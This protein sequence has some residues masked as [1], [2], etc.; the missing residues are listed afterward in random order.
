[1]KND[2]SPEI[3]HHG[4]HHQV[5][6]SC[7]EL[8]VDEKNSILIDCGLSQGEG[9]HEPEID[10][11]I[12]RIRALVL[13]HVHLDHCGRL[14]YLLAAGFTGPIFCSEPSA[15]L[16]PLVI[17]DGLKVGVTR[18][19]RLIELYLKQVQLQ[20]VPMSYW[21]WREIS[22][23]GPAAL[24]IKLQPAGHILG[25]A[26]VECGVGR[27]ANEKRIIFSGDL[28]PPYTPLLGAPQSPYRADELVLE[29][30]YGDRI[31]E[32]RK[33]RRAVLKKIL[34]QALADCGVVLIPAFSIGRT[35]ELLYE[36]EEIIHR[37]RRAQVVPGV[38]W[39]NLDIIVDS[40]LAA[41]FTEAYR[42][43]MV[44]WDNEARRKSSSGRHP[45]SFE[46]LT[47]IDT[48]AEHLATIDYLKRNRRPAI[49]VAASG[50][51]TGGRIVNYLKAF[52]GE[53]ATDVLFVGY[54]AK[55]TA[56]RDIQQYGPQGGY[57]RLNG[58]KISIRAAI[59]T[60]SGYSAHADRDN[61]LNF[62]GR[63]RRL[64]RK[65]RLVHGE[66]DARNALAEEIRTRYPDST[67]VI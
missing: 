5:T 14:P 63:M 4:G 9:S 8:V 47:T 62:I 27:G 42:K 52:L 64:P 22:L 33:D 66:D 39:D 3:I 7:H 30:T 49:I 38:S 57:V 10:F 11:P 36:I 59:H 54:Q 44:Y 53:A 61:L 24:R 32:G 50:M 31:H 21:S 34:S 58:E 45:L 25:S 60:V 28:G 17:E 41:R 46:Q 48:H 29:S 37:D 35:Q 26:Y 18:N 43:L 1:M 2:Q 23:S 6:G 55:G 13:T 67:V 56:G 65:I 16:L 20:L 40:P 15:L 51:C 12:A 19:R